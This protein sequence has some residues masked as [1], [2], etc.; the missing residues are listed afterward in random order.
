MFRSGFEP[1]T[2]G[3]SVLYSTI[4]LPKPAFGIIGL[5]PMNVDIKNRCLNHLAISQINSFVLVKYKVLN[6]LQKHADFLPV[7]KM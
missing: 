6:K 1:P 2:K 3:F 7:L 5:E 4:K